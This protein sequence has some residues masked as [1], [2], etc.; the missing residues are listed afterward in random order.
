MDLDDVI[1]AF[2]LDVVKIVAGHKMSD[3]LAGVGFRVDDVACAD[4]LQ[5][6]GVFLRHGLGPNVGN[7]GVEQVAGGDD[8]S[9][10]TVADGH[11]G[12]VEIGCVDL[13][14]RHHVCH[15]GLYGGNL[16]RPAVHQFAVLVDGKH[17]LAHHV[18]RG[19]HRAAKTPQTNYENASGVVSHDVIHLSKFR[20]QKTIFMC[21]CRQLQVYEAV[22]S[23]DHD[24][25]GGVADGLEIVWTRNRVGDGERSEPPDEH[26][27]GENV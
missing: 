13:F 4:A 21:D 15:V 22:S 27:G 1:G 20:L 3:T 26:G 9:F 5:D 17:I 23:A 14:Q 8:G 12:R 7:A 6:A 10:D 25:L 16:R 2:K 11:D 24:L 19:G 18:E